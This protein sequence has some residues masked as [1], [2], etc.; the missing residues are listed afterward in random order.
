VK[1]L[2]QIDG[3]KRLLTDS[4]HRTVTDAQIGSWDSKLDKSGGTMTGALTLHDDPTEQMHAAT[5]KYVDDT[6]D[7]VLGD[8]ADILASI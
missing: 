7:T 3:A 8:I 2:N 6:I 1:F 4:G 5:K